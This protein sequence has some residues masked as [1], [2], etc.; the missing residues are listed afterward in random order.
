MK[1]RFS[2]KTAK[3]T[4]A[5]SLLLLAVSVLSIGAVTAAP[6]AISNVDFTQCANDS[7]GG[8]PKGLCDFLGG[9]VGPKSTYYDGM[10]VPQR[11]MWDG[12]TSSGANTH[13]LGFGY[14]WSSSNGVHAYDIL[15]SW[16][17]AR[18]LSSQIAGLTMTTGYSSTQPT[19]SDP[20]ENVTSSGGHYADC[21][22]IHG[23]PGG[24][25]GVSSFSTTYTMP[26]NDSFTSANCDPGQ[27]LTSSKQSAFTAIYGPRTFTIWANAPITVASF[28][29]QHFSDKCSTPVATDSGGTSYVCVQ[30]VYTSTATIID[31]E[32]APKIGE[33]CDSNQPTSFQWGCTHGG[34]SQISGSPY[35]FFSTVGGG[36]DGSGGS[37]DNQI[38]VNNSPPTPSMVTSLSKVSGTFGTVVT[39]TVTITGVTTISGT[40]T[41]FYCT[42]ANT[43]PCLAGTQLGSPIAV[44][45]ATSPVVVVSPSLTPANGVTCFRVLFTSQNANNATSNSVTTTGSPNGECVT[46]TSS[47]AVRLSSM[48]AARGNNGAMLIW[49]TGSEVNTAG[50]NLYRAESKDGPYTRINAQ[51]IA[52]TNTVTGNSYAYEDTTALP[53]KTYFYQ[54]EDVELNGTSARH[55]PIA[56]NA[57]AADVM[58]GGLPLALGLGL[59]A[60][61]LI[62]SGLFITLKKLNVF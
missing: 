62:A 7:G 10:A 45:S 43:T 15:V 5:V 6:A 13:T 22:A 33:G 14:Q 54:L 31:L 12:I 58:K 49:K 36:V 38:Q 4:L 27:C 24:S 26:D 18:Q 34:S 41:F 48:S 53:G 44:N 19:Q 9:N 20:C 28:T 61:A 17:Q 55:D 21:R 40:V 30:I 23:L 11:D 32:I 2:N 42:T 3:R 52:A 8:I 37:L 39:D 50:F 57:P 59:G 56:L 16:A 46:I 1:Y 35:H 60:F 25:A 47:T 51:L 29:L